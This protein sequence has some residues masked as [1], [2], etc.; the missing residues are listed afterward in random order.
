MSATIRDIARKCGVSEGT[1]DRALNNREGIRKSTKEMILKVAA[2]LNYEPNHMASCLAKGSTKTIGVVCAGMRNPFFSA[3]I[4][5]TEQMAYENG[6]YLTLVLNHNDLEKEREGVTY[7]AKRQVDGLIMMP[8]GQGEEYEKWLTSFNIP[9][10]TVYNRIS[11]KFA[12]I[13]VDGREIMEEAVSRMVNKGYKRVL[14]LDLGYDHESAKVHNR[15]S[16]NKRRQGYIDGVK[17]EGLGE[18]VIMTEVNWDGIEQFI[19]AD[20]GKPAIL[21]PFDNIAIKMLN[22]LREHG[23]NVPDDVGLM[24]FDNIPILEA[25]SPRIYSVDCEIRDLGKKAFSVLL[26]LIQGQQ[27]VSD[28]VTTY[29]FTEGQSL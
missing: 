9:I 25:I 7:L 12:H 11:D 27:D 18:P 8:L 17:K 21:C 26:Q 5:A 23:M 22:I 14:Y 1:V 20:G 29:T 16:L 4:E 28:Y 24:G 3:L 13:D 2:E 15:Y 19:R 10:V 6:Y